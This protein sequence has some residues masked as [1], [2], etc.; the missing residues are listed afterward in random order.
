MSPGLVHCD[1]LFAVN[2]DPASREENETLSPSRRWI[3]LFDWFGTESS[4][5]HTAL[6]L[7]WPCPDGQCCNYPHFPAAVSSLLKAGLDC[8]RSRIQFA[9]PPVT[10]CDSFGDKSGLN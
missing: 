5:G 8:L 3:Q 9:V 2:I 4:D 10:C 7:P 6:G 1:K